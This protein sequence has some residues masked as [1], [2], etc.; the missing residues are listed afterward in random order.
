MS[1]KPP[2][3]SEIEWRVLDSL[4]DLNGKSWKEAR[5]EYH[6]TYDAMAVWILLFKAE[7]ID[8]AHQ[9]FRDV[10]LGYSDLVRFSVSYS[11]KAPEGEILLEALSSDEIA[12][13]GI[14]RALGSNPELKTTGRSV[15]RS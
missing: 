6:G 2:S 13:I 8:T 4:Q 12:L 10:I 3:P 5:G 1:Y 14:T 15:F 7:D 9:T 11:V